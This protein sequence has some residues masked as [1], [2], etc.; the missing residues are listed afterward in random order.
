MTNHNPQIDAY[1]QKAQPFARPILIKLRGL[2][3]KACPQIEER[4]KWGMPSFE[5]HGIV[6][7]F[8]AFKQHV[9][10]GLWKAKLIDDPTN[11]MATDASSAMGGGK[12]KSVKDLP[13]EA[14]LLG[15]MR[16]AVDLNARGVK[17]PR[18]PTAKKP[19]PKTPPDLA[20]A[21]KRSAK[22]AAVYQD[23]SPSHKR[24]YIEWITEAKQPATRQKR[25]KQAIE[26]IAQGKPRNWKYM[27]T[28]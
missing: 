20:A 16:Q 11:A 1:I 8:A 3:H 7:G 15:L 2:F 12:L 25:I 24:E 28:S 19:P 9:S 23:F 13:P 14:I 5:H 22:A 17:L 27:R 10:W 6:G 4:L 18:T 21:L 26:W